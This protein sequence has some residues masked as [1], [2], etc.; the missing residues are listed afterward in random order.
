MDAII[1]G[2]GSN[3]ELFKNINNILGL[4]LSIIVIHRA[5][6]FVIGMFFTRK[7]KPA[8]KNINM[9]LSLRLEMKKA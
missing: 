2:I 7:F 3:Y 5:F 6:Y 8:K 4:I 9:L 1:K